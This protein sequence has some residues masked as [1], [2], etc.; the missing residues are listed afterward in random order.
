MFQDG[1][2][3]GNQVYGQ[4]FVLTDD[5]IGNTIETNVFDITIEEPINYTA[6]TPHIGW[7]EGGTE[8][9]PYS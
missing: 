3:E 4:I 9:C 5:V 6:L 2:C 7:N 1:A 8:V